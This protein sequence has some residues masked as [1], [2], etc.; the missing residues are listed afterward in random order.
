MNPRPPNARRRE[1]IER[2][3]FVCQPGVFLVQVGLSDS[4][5]SSLRD[6]WIK[7]MTKIPAIICSIKIPELFTDRQC[8]QN[9]LEWLENI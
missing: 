6:L 3:S 5:R 4:D 1:N 9:M 2:E 8:Q 7:L